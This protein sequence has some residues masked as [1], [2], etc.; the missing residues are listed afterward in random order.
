MELPPAVLTI[1][2][3]SVTLSSVSW[4]NTSFDMYSTVYRRF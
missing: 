4:K 1:K 3:H 2:K